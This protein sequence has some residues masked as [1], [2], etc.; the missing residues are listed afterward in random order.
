[1]TETPFTND[2]PHNNNPQDSY[3]RVQRWDPIAESPDLEYLHHHW[4]LSSTVPTPQPCP[5]SRPK[6]FV[7]SSFN[8]LLNSSLHEYLGVEQQLFASLV[9]LT[10]TLAKRVD[11]LEIGQSRLANESSHLKEEVT[12]VSH[13]LANLAE[14]HRSW[15]LELL[16]RLEQIEQTERT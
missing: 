13:Q 4:A 12:T 9:R 1:M 11:L 3:E 10:D 2:N 15:G 8:R 14:Q 6:E 5:P 7:R 16:E